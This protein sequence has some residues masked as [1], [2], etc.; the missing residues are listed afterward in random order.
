MVDDR[1]LQIIV[2]TRDAMARHVMRMVNEGEDNVADRVQHAT[3]LIAQGRFDKVKLGHLLDEDD[4]S[5]K[6]EPLKF[7]SNKK[8]AGTLFALA[9][10]KI[11]HITTSANPADAPNAIP[12]LNSIMSKILKLNSKKLPWKLIGRWWAWITRK[13]AASAK[14]FGK[15]SYNK[16]GAT[17][18]ISWVRQQSSAQD[19]LNEDLL[20]HLSK[21]GN[22]SG[23]IC[24]DSDSEPNQQ[25][26]KRKRGKGLQKKKAALA[27]KEEGG[28]S[29]AAKKDDDKKAEHAKGVKP[30]K[31][32]PMPAPGTDLLTAFNTKFG[33]GKNPKGKEVF[34]CWDFH[35]P[36]GC[37]WGKKCFF[38]HTK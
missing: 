27:K 17:F 34:A 6:D 26:P 35:N 2:R 21:R 22:F 38:Y 28:E 20:E 8:D 36:Q 13:M 30:G 1:A 23:E 33:K 15:G 10:S 19:Q 4:N 37:T 25:P 16:S 5:S 9:I 24:S 18:D 14:S 32:V 12:M 11:I 7:F 29:P 3:S 31:R